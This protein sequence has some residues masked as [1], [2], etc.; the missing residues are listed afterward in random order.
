MTYLLALLF[1]L[2]ALMGLASISQ[3]YAAAKQAQAAIEAGRAAEIAS[4]GNLVMIVT[5]AILLLAALA[6]IGWLLL[7]PRPADVRFAPRP[8]TLAAPDSSTL[9]TLVLMQMLQNQR[10]PAPMIPLDEELPELQ[11]DSWTR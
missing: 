3:S 2:A 7:R 4:A 5:L 10:P 11:D 6:T 8:K 9:L 1:F